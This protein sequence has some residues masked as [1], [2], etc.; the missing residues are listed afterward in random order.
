MKKTT[1]LFSILLLMVMAHITAQNA[2]P[3][4]DQT[5]GKILRVE[6]TCWWVGMKNADVQLLVYG[7]QMA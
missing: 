2:N 3:L 5:P 4:S 6:P 7:N 1:F